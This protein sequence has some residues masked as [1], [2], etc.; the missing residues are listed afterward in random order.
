MIAAVRTFA[1]I[2]TIKPN[3]KQSENR[4]EAVMEKY[5]VCKAPNPRA[6]RPWHV[7]MRVRSA[8]ATFVAAYESEE[9]ARRGAEKFNTES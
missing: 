1:R 5:Y 4:P 2:R 9:A 7:R 3:L 6:K 8:T